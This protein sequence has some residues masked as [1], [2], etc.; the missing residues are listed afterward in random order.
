MTEHIHTYACNKI[1]LLKAYIYNKIYIL[2]LEQFLIHN[3]Y[4]M[5]LLLLYHYYCLK[6]NKIFL[7]CLAYCLKYNR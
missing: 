6:T 3:K 4:C 1:C 7:V 5:S 2:K